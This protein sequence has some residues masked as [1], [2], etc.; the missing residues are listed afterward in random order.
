MAVITWAILPSFE[1]TLKLIRLEDWKSVE[2]KPF[3]TKNGLSWVI[4]DI[5]TY[6]EFPE[7]EGS[8]R[9]F[10]Q[11]V[12]DSVLLLIDIGEWERA[13]SLIHLPLEL[14]GNPTF[15]QQLKGWGFFDIQLRI[16]QKL[17]SVQEEE[18]TTFCLHNFASVYYDL[19][20]F[21]DSKRYFQN[22]VQNFME[23]GDMGQVGWQYH[24]LA[25]VNLEIGDNAEAEEYLLKAIKLFGQ[26]DT[27]DYGGIAQSYNDLA[28]VEMHY[29]NVEKAQE[30]HEKAVEL[31][32]THPNIG[33]G[34]T[35]AWVY[36]G[37]SLFL[38]DHGSY[39][40][41][42]KYGLKSLELFNGD[43][44]GTSWT[45]ARISKLY[46]YMEEYERSRLYALNAKELFHQLGDK[47]GLAIILYIMARLE[48]EQKN[49]KAAQENLYELMGILSHRKDHFK[50]SL[51]MDGFSKLALAQENY[52]LAVQL[53]SQVEKLQKGMK[54][55]RI[56][57]EQEAFQKS[58]SLCRAK[59]GK[60]SFEQL[61]EKGENMMIAEVF[62]VIYEIYGD[63]R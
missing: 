7:Q 22:S 9:L 32:E 29:G 11:R 20:Q 12:V 50:N 46:L 53:L 52:K 56:E 3:S 5:K 40:V 25:V 63:F 19:G 1:D 57:R 49:F 13:Y 30:Y 35:R 39:E 36:Q 59:L 51:A 38:M 28:R 18:V 45:C 61:W 15:F 47:S 37:Y 2:D 62:S 10:S 24:G 41:A 60:T 31:Y 17:S 4:E 54:K 58:Y 33:T 43:K 48:I 55:V 21:E 14:E 6:R 27:V 8:A 44:G 23:I 34:E 16:L 26:L 42:E